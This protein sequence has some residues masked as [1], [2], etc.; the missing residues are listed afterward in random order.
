MRPLDDSLI[1]LARGEE[2]ME[3]CLCRRDAPLGV[4]RVVLSSRCPLH[5]GGT[6][7]WEDA[8]CDMPPRLYAEAE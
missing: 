7:V 8:T 2:Q 3:R 6:V 5:G 1:R 4:T